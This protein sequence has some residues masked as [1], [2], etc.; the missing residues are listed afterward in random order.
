MQNLYNWLVES[1]QRLTARRRSRGWLTI[2]RGQGTRGLV[3]R[4]QEPS[5]A[6]LAAIRSAQFALDQDPSGDALALALSLLEPHTVGVFE[7]ANEGSFTQFFPSRKQILAWP[8]SKGATRIL[9][10]NF[11]R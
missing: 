5:Q 2:Q 7:V 11:N 9:G 8:L 6:E 1:N 4:A 3:I 10:R